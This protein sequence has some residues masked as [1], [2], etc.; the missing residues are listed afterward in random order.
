MGF[1]QEDI[2][3]Y[4]LLFPELESMPGKQE[5]LTHVLDEWIKEI[6]REMQNI[7]EENNLAPWTTLK[8]VF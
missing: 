2:V 4:Y 7:S 6:S 8:L 1:P 5:A 3:L